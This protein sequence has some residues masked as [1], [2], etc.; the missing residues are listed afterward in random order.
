MEE[1]FER[2]FQ[3]QIIPNLIPHK[4]FHLEEKRKCLVTAHQSELKVTS[5]RVESCVEQ[6]IFSFA[7]PNDGSFR[8]NFSKTFSR[9]N[10]FYLKKKF[11][12]FEK[13]MNS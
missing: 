4:M 3:V 5:I 2:E 7:Q 9:V 8:V 1:L 13:M 6:V 11:P 10:N 12:H